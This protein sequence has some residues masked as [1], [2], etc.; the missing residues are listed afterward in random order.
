MDTIST[1][2][3]TTDTTDN[4]TT[5]ATDSPSYQAYQGGST[6]DQALSLSKQNQYNIEYLN[7]E[8]KKI[9]GMSDEIDKMKLDIDTINSQMGD[10]A[11][12]A[13]DLGTAISGGAT[14]N[15]L[16][17]IDVGAGDTTEDQTADVEAD[18]DNED[19]END[20]DANAT[21]NML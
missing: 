20:D 1:E 9:G 16:G 11:S 5:N 7:S 12:S 14:T 21:S 2:E 17:E 3:T 13:G 15:E 6:A 4:A 18:I 10:L 19:G 8:V